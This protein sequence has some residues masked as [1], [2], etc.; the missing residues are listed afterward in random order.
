MSDFSLIK[1]NVDWCNGPTFEILD[2]TF[3]FYAINFNQKIKNNWC[4]VHESCNFKPFSYFKTNFKFRIKWQIKAWGFTDNIVQVFEET[5]NETNKNICIKLNSDNYAD[6][7]LWC[8]KSIK[9]SNN[10]NF[11][12]F[13]ISK[14]ANRLKIEFKNGPVRFFNQVDNFE[15]FK[16]KEK[17]YAVYNIDRKEI[18]THTANWWETGLIFINHSR[19][20]K[21]WHHPQD[22]V[23]MTSEEIYNNIMDI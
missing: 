4:S 13:I 1:A 7:K 11:N 22:W 21:S 20:V 15:I 8:L 19:A 18:L 5:Y 14:F 16:H 6:H 2:N 3:P 12:L 23:G 17:I 9:L 10:C